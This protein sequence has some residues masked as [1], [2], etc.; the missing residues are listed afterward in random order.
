MKKPY[1]EV[2][3]T[4][5]MAGR[6]APQSTVFGV[7]GK[8]HESPFSKSLGGLVHHT[9]DGRVQKGTVSAKDVETERNIKGKPSKTKI[10]GQHYGQ[11]L[12]GGLFMSHLG[13]RL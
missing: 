9:A 11:V 8:T 7:I 6:G 4:R 1:M 3:E 13:A 10:P 12:Y 5:Q 2:E